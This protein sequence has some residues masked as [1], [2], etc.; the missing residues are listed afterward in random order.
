MNSDLTVVFPFKRVYGA[1]R[2][3]D[4][5]FLATLTNMVV[6][7]SRHVPADAHL[8]MILTELHFDRPANAL[9]YGRYKLQ[10]LPTDYATERAYF[11][12]VKARI[13]SQITLQSKRACLEA[14]L[15]AFEHADDTSV[16]HI[17][18]TLSLHYGYTHV[19]TT[20]DK[21]KALAYA[22]MKA[23]LIQME[24][25]EAIIAPS[26]VKSAG[27]QRAGLPGALLIGAGVVLFGAAIGALFYRKRF[28]K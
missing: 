17:L 24:Q 19:P 1:D 11:D 6:E 18:V 21:I 13:E 20:D 2:K 7:D 26:D 16:L 23:K 8:L 22:F 27:N 4:A 15:A 9:F 25:A 5:L 12:A 10:M 28:L 3:R 14:M